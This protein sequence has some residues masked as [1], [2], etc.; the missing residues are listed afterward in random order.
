MLAL[1]IIWGS[2]EAIYPSSGV[3]ALGEPRYAARALGVC[4]R[5]REREER[6]RASRAAAW[7]LGNTQEAKGMLLFWYEARLPQFASDDRL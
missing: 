3:A 1:H 6:P 7:A 5:S 4:I 2:D